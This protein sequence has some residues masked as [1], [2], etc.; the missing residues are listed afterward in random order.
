[1]KNYNKFQI[2]VRADY[3]LVR[4]ATKSESALM[5]RKVARVIYDTAASDSAGVSNKTIAAH[6]LGIY[7]PIKAIVINA[8]YQVLTTFTSA[9][10]AAT[11]AL[12]VTNANDVVT[13]IAISDSSNP[14]DAGNFATKVGS[15][16][17][18]GNA[19]T[20]INMGVAKAASW[21]GPVSAEKEII[22]TVAVEALTAGK[23][24]LWLEYMI[25]E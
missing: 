9:T 15:F 7:L 14:W 18:D 22:A 17:L 11:I 10:D 25:G 12:K 23:L 24:I 19:L 6:G 16:A 4:G 21:I 13:A 2:D 1:M 5:M 20:A 3:Q 8:Y